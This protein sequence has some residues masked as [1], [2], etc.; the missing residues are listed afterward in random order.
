M[1]AEE[2]N[3]GLRILGGNGGSKEMGHLE[4]LGTLVIVTWA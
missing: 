1:G 2:S 4:D 3:L